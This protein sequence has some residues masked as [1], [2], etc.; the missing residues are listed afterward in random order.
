MSCTSYK[1]VIAEELEAYLNFI[2][3]ENSELETQRNELKSC[4]HQRPAEEK[5]IIKDVLAMHNEFDSGISKINYIVDNLA[6]LPSDKVEK[7][8]QAEIMAADLVRLQSSLVQKHEVLCKLST[9]K[10]HFKQL[11]DETHEKLR[12]KQSQ[13]DEDQFSITEIA[14]YEH[15]NLYNKKLRLLNSELTR[16][17]SLNNN[18]S[19]SWYHSEADSKTAGLSTAQAT[20]KLSE[21]VSENKKIEEEIGRLNSRFLSKDQFLSLKK[22]IESKNERIGELKRMLRDLNENIVGL[23][24]PGRVQDSKLKIRMLDNIVG[25][26][27]PF[28]I[29]EALSPRS[30]RKSS[31]LLQDIEAGLLRV[32]AMTSPVPKG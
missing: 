3:A 5:N 26:K 19:G 10:H 15:G 24:S 6:S 22:E 12:I 18:T 16:L 11:K 30:G 20:I 28:Q 2:I 31:T 1:R 29:F 9:Q 8:C 14:N 7:T 4:F 21:Q 17:K 13:Y 32:R 25:R 27:S 23:G